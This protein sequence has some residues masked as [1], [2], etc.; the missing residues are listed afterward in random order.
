MGNSRECTGLFSTFQTILASWPLSVI[1]L[2][3]R[4]NYEILEHAINTFNQ[5]GETNEWIQRFCE[6]KSNE[7]SNISVLGGITA[8]VISTA[9]TW[10]P[11]APV[12]ATV[13]GAWYCGLIFALTA[14]SVAAQQNIA[15][16]R[17]KAHPKGFDNLR[18]MFMEAKKTLNLPIDRTEAVAIKKQPIYYQLY[19]WQVPIMML[20][21]ANLVLATSIIYLVAQTESATV[22]IWVLAATAF[23]GTNYLASWAILNTSTL[24][25]SDKS[26]KQ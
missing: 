12:P 20:N 15:L 13:R 23:A 26:H 14:V 24:A 25:A 17:A 3:W 10:D 9:F 7:L 5:D 6:S 21:F 1:F 19:L 4:T 11:S 22:I 18:Y 16:I 2:P 8:A